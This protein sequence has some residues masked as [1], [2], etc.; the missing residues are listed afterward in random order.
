MGRVDEGNRNVNDY[1]FI[2]TF[3]ICKNVESNINATI[4]TSTFSPIYGDKNVSK[5]IYLLS[6]GNSLTAVDYYWLDQISDHDGNFTSVDASKASKF[7][8]ETSFSGTL[9]TALVK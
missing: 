4:H 7:K 1:E 5:L 9:L 8:N 6:G 2:F 3:L